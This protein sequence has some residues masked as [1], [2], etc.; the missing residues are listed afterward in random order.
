MAL[1][2]SL[3]RRRHRP[4]I[5]CAG[6]VAL[7]AVLLVARLAGAGA[8]DLNDATWEGCSELL[9]IAKSE[10]GKD[11]VLVQSVLDWQE[12]SANDGVL[13]IHPLPVVDAEEATAFMRAGGRLAVVDDYG[14]GD[15]LLSHF[16]IHRR[17]LPSRPEAVLRNKPA[18]PVAQPALDADGSGAVGLHPT[19]AQVERVVLNHGTGLSHPDLTPILVV[20]ARG[21]EPVAVAV[22]GQVEAGRLLAMGDSSVFINMMLRYPGN[23]NFAEGLVH[24]LVDGERAV[25]GTGRLF[26]YANEFDE[27]AGFGGVM[28]WRKTVDRRLVELREGLAAWRR[29]GLPGWLHTAVASLAGIALLWWAITAVVR[30]YRGRVPRFARPVPRVAQ[31]GAAGRV[32]VLAAPTSPP[33]LALLELRSALTESLAHHF[34]RPVHTRTVDLVDE[35]L[36]AGL[37][38][39][40]DADIRSALAGMRRAE[41]GVVSGTS[42]RVTRRDVVRA[43][44][45]VRQLLAACGAERHQASP[46]ASERSGRPPARSRKIGPAMWDRLRRTMGLGR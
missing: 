17:T 40:A 45:A 18:L 46:R 28:P 6:A 37:D 2:D 31:G 29:D 3:R 8:F 16:R 20:R 41:A 14:R 27:R 32:A 35:A 7:V 26:I 23:R 11:R 13:V 15:R 12:L 1:L 4:G 9:S 5:R 22:A 21:E 30:I 42:P 24:Y 34:E 39:P 36:R 25:D 19:V 38:P 44:R 10:L 33:A 43:S